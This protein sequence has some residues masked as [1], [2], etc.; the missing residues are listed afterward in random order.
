MGIPRHR[1]EARGAAGPSRRVEHRFAGRVDRHVLRVRNRGQHDDA[2]SR[3]A[4]AK[5][6]IEPGEIACRDRRMAARNS[7]T[8]PGA[9]LARAR[10]KVV[11][12][13]D[14]NSDCGHSSSTP[15]GA[16]A[17]HATPRLDFGHAAR[18]DAGQLHE[19][20]V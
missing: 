20:S 16:P 3:D 10:M 7:T 2:P 1:V 6:A 9:A 12:G 19:R 13:M 4:D 14:L 15:S 18:A 8:A 5:R 17:P 11:L